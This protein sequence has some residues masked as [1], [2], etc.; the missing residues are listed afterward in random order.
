MTLSAPRAASAGQSGGGDRASD[1]EGRLIAEA[2]R[3]H[4]AAGSPLGEDPRAETAA[5]EA[6]GDLEHKIIVHAQNRE[7]L[8][9][10]EVG[11][12]EEGLV[13]Q[14]TLIAVERAAPRDQ[15]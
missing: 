2:L 11:Q 8:A 15:V 5:R 3:F 6:T 4:Q 7:A 9:R 12:D 14:E 1:H 13:A 10:Q